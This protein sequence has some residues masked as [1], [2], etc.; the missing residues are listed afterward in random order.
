MFENDRETFLNKMEDYLRNG[1]KLT[2]SSIKVYLN[3]IRKLLDSEYSVNDLCGTADRLWKDY[4]VK[5]QCYDPKDHGNT[6]AAVKHVASLVREKFLAEFG[7]PYVSY[8]KAWSSFR[9]KGKHECGYVIDNGIITFSYN[10]GFSK[11]KDIGKIISATHLRQL[12]NIFER[13]RKKGHLA[14]SNSCIST[15]HGHLHKYAYVFG[16]ACG[17]NCGCLFEGDS[18]YVDQLENEFQDLINKLRA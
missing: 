10:I 3:R 6:R 14:S 4:G 8:E 2:E 7:C 13:A 15:V 9:P 18:V 16:D 11:G 1:K 12:H 17:S 5:G